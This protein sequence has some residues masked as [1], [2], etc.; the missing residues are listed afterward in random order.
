MSLPLRILRDT[1]W[2][3]IGALISILAIFISVVTLPSSGGELAVIHNS[4]VKFDDLIPG[5]RVQL[6]AQGL[7]QELNGTV[8]DYYILM[9]TAKRPILPADFTSPIEAVKGLGAKRVLLVDS[10]APTPTPTSA[11]P[12]HGASF[13]AFTWAAQGDGW[14]AV[15]ALLNPNEQSCVIVISELASSPVQGP[16]NSVTWRARVANVQLAVYASQLA[17]YLR[18]NKPWSEYTFFTQVRLEG[19]SVYWFVLLQSII[20]VATIVLA[21]HSRWIDSG[22]RFVAIRLLAAMLLSTSTAEI[23]V[24]IFVNRRGPMQHPIVW[25]LLFLHASVLGYFAI[26]SLRIP[27]PPTQALTT[28]RKGRA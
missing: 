25:P 5:Q 4:R 7:L 11:Q 13:V 9:N 16:P 8:I 23:L 15:P 20:F 26:R 21:T 1:V 22:S 14:T 10:C 3:S 17:Y 12:F 6:L 2:Q 19:T 27:R 28:R 18:P 24:D